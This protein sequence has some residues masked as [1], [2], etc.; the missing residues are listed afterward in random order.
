MSDNDWVDDPAPS[1]GEWVDDPPK[2]SSS[3]LESGIMHGLQGASAGYLDELS[4]A[5]EAAGRAVGV[6]GVGGSFSDLGLADDGPTLDWETLRDAYKEA[7]D[8]KRGVLKKQSSDNPM[9]S[10]AGEFVGMV[11]SP[12]NKIAKGMSLAKGGAALGGINALGGSEAEDLGGMAK[13]TTTGAI[14]GGV[15]GKGVDVASPLISKAANAIGNR[16]KSGA[17]NFGARALGAERGTIKSMGADKVK[18]AGRYAL[19]EGILSP[20]ASTDDLISRNAAK[21]A[22]GAGKMNQVYNQIDEAGASTFNPLDEAVNVENKIGN[23]YRSPINRGE[24]NQLENT[25]ESM[26]MRGDKPIPLREAQALKEE[27]GKVANWKNSLNVT[28]KEK[29]ARDAYGVVNEAIDRAAQEGAET[30]GTEGLKETLQQGKALYGSSKGAEKLLENKL[31]REQGNK[32]LGL[33]D[34]NVLGTGGV[35]AAMTGGASILP[36]AGLLGAKRGLEK[37]GSQTAAVGLDKISKALMKSPKMAEL[38]QK[39]PAAFQALA[40]K[41]EQNMTSLPRAAEGQQDNSVEQ[42]EPLKNVPPSKDEIIRKAAGSKYAQVL[43]NAAQSGEQSFN[44]AHF[45]LQQRDPEYR[46]IINE[47]NGQ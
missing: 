1:D 11:A 7:R 44:A 15:L 3:V 12:L 39:N 38:Y 21:Q 26:V 27:L 10:G 16:L 47:G 6:K 9:A 40:S 43:Q 42:Q 46:K 2:E 45:V 13:D 24:T 19:D 4:G 30:I 33:T 32:L 23:F 17:E 18:A 8:K 20:L 5:T 31:A 29:M 41:L 35:G 14:L 22:E 25:L 28:D 36:T 37:Y 34:W